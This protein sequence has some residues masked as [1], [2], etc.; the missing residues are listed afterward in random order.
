MKIQIRPVIVAALCAMLLSGCVQYDSKRGVEVK[1][2]SVIT[3][4]L[5][6]GTS[7]RGEVLALLGPPSQI[8][9]LDEES[10][11]YYLFE[12]TKG[13]GYILILYNRFTVDARYDRAVFFFD[14]NDILRDYSTHIHEP[15]DK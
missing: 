1:W 8:I 11:L 2:Q 14:D 4:Q 9:S 10:V 3:E 15:E 13:N 5:Q 12:R 7:T 6:K